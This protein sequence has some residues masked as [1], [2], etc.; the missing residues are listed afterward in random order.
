[1]LERMLEAMQSA[2]SRPP[3][4]PT[5]LQVIINTNNVELVAILHGREN[6]I[7]VDDLPELGPSRLP[8]LPEDHPH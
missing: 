5:R 3:A 7:V 4:E 2:P 6:P 8:Q 1:M